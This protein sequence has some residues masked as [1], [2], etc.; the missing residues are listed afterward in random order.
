MIGTFINESELEKIFE[1]KYI[2]YSVSDIRKSVPRINFKKIKLSKFQD[3]DSTFERKNITK[4]VLDDGLLNLDLPIKRITTEESYE[5][6]SR[7]PLRKKTEQGE[8]D[9]QQSSGLRTQSLESSL[10]S[11]QLSVLDEEEEKKKDVTFS[12]EAQIVQNEESVILSPAI[13]SLPPFKEDVLSASGEEFLLVWPPVEQKKAKKRSYKDKHKRKQEKKQKKKPYFLA[14]QKPVEKEQKSFKATT[15]P[16]LTS[17]IGDKSFEN[18]VQG[19]LESELL[20]APS[21]ELSQEQNIQQP[22]FLESEKKL[23]GE[24]DIEALYKKPG[25]REPLIQGASVQVTFKALIPELPTSEISEFVTNIKSKDVKLETV[26]DQSNKIDYGIE[27]VG[28]ARK[29]FEKYGINLTSV[30]IIILGGLAATLGYLLWSYIPLDLKIIPTHDEEKDKLLVRDI[31]KKTHAYKKNI[32]LKKEEEKVDKNIA[33][34]ENKIFKPITEQERLTL[35][36]KARES[37]ESRSDPFGQDSVLPQSVIEERMK[38]EEDKPPPD[39]PMERKQVELVGVIST[40]NKNIAL[41]NVF[42]ADYTVNSLDDK[43]TKETKLKTALSMAVPNRVEVSL[44]DPVEDWYIKQIT[45]GKA[46]N[47]EP[48]I[49]LVKGDKKFKLKVG[50]KVLLPEEKAPEEIQEESDTDDTSKDSSL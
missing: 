30:R 46:R 50:Q 18:I 19:G 16:W 39:V 32:G 28:K 47:E 38:E 8:E 5:T 36:Q 41:V 11:P 43:P 22:T 13:V 27:F 2:S 3:L 24:S 49:E 34:E 25:V 4:V 6:T 23:T 12:L 9:K 48:T 31:F 26:F 1:E 14:Q 45:K 10:L 35:I 17:D 15:F 42:T 44:L 20:D 29:M 33:Q 7:N 21:Q 37:L 40:N